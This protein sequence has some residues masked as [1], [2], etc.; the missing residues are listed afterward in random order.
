[1]VIGEEGKK[2]PL[3]RPQ[4]ELHLA[5]NEG[6]SERGNGIRLPPDAVSTLPSKN[7]A[8]R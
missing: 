2:R 4:R 7:F 1:V 3:S 8:L 6:V 5:E